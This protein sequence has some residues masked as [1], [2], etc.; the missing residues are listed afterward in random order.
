MKNNNQGFS[1]IEVLVTVLITSGGLL[2]FAGILNKSIAANRQ[3]YTRSQATIIAN[4]IIERMRA[5]RA[6][7]TAGV[8]NIEMNSTPAGGDFSAEDLAS[9]ITIIESNLPKGDGS[10]SSD[11]NGNITIV[12]QWDDD[13][14]GVLTTFRTQ[15][16]I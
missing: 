9:W 12:I 4:D 3:A 15:T 14:D 6:L 11:G 5:N 10:V 13:N 16:S 2:G 7:A 1:L 8:Y